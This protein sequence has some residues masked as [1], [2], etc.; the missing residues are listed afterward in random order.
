MQ[1]L[2]IPK[3]TPND[4]IDEEI[5]EIFVEEVQEVLQDII[6]QFNT[7]KNNPADSSS[8]ENLRRAFHTLKGSG[9]LVG[10]TVIGELGWRFENLFN[11][12]IDGTVPRNDELLSLVGQVE[13]VLPSMIEQFK[14]NQP[15]PEDIVRLISQA[16]A[17]TH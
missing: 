16:D 17:L 5:L 2:E 10:A 6:N 11:K 3:Q 15:P 7:W 1:L 13:K 8:V 4:E 9:R 12:I 14:Q